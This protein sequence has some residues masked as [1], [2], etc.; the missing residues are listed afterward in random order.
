M[1]KQSGGG[2]GGGWWWW[3]GGRRA[4]PERSEIGVPQ[5]STRRE[6]VRSGGGFSGIS[7]KCGPA[8][9]QRMPCGESASSAVRQEARQ[10]CAV[11]RERWRCRNMSQF[12]NANVRVFLRTAEAPCCGVAE[13][14][15]EAA[16][17]VGECSTARAVTVGA[18][19]GKSAASYHVLAS[20]HAPSSVTAGI[21]AVCSLSS[22]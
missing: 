11:S 16:R 6:G 22:P 7:E 17:M 1:S 8:S 19:A 14:K 10:L 21:Q 20:A 18:I 13:W 4:G 2:G 15:S 5:C 12:C 9:Q 3:W